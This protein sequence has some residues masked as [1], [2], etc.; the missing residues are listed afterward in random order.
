MKFLKA[1][2]RFLFSRR[3]W[4]F[5]GVALLCAL[6][7]L[8]G[9][10][11]SVGDMVPLADDLVRMMVIAVILV[12]WLFSLLLA[13]L[14]AAKKN[15]L[16]VTELAQPAPKGLPPGEANVAEINTK[17]SAVLTEMKR[18]KL[19]GKK[20]LRDMPWYVIIGPPGPARPPR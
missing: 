12:F 9:P 11:V 14:R 16:F 13:Q 2:F 15:Q 7:W 17:F 8:F 20:F 5:I 1:I 3:L 6:I 10:L 18:S 4:T 19:G